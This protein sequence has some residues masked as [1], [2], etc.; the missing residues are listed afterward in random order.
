MNNLQG[1]YVHGTYLGTRIVR[2][3][4]DANGQTKETLYCGVSYTKPGAYG[5]EHIVKELCI[6]KGLTDKGIP[7]K[8]HS[9]EGKQI[10]LPFFE[11]AWSNGKGKTLFLANN[12]EQMFAVKAA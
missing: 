2:G 10:A 6:S 11:M 5:D 7:A 3:K 1:E 9:Y 12:V 4:P 8:L